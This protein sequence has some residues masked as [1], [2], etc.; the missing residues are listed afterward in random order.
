MFDSVQQTQLHSNRNNIIAFRD[1]SRLF[2]F[3]LHI[4]IFIFSGIRGFSIS[5]LISTDGSS[6]SELQF[7][8][9]LRHIIYTAETHNFP[10]G[11]FLCK[12]INRIIYFLAVCP[13]PGAATGTGGR[14]RD[15]HATGRGF[16]RLFLKCFIC[17]LGAHEIAGVVG[18]SFGNIHLA[19][20][21]LPWEFPAIYPDNFAHPRDVYQS[22]RESSTTIFTFR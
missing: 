4:F 16:C 15:V 8:D 18:Y 5:N 17:I 19:G 22:L 1:N 12:T 2:E 7:V 13:F 20:Y 21:D 10:T 6:A 11:S 3:P 9:G 14:I